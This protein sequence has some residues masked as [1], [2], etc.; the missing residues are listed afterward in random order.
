MGGLPAADV[1]GIA[2]DHA[3]IQPAFLRRF[4]MAAAAAG[5]LLAA[6]LW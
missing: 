3:M 1:R 4:G 2:S 6:M 5:G